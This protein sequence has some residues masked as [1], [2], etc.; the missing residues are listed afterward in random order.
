[1]NKIFYILVIMLIVLLL[2]PR[3][4]TATLVSY[5]LMNGVTGDSAPGGKVSVQQFPNF[6]PI[7][8]DGQYTYA[9]MNPRRKQTPDAGIP[10]SWVCTSSASFCTGANCTAP[11]LQV[12]SPTVIPP[13]TGFIVTYHYY[14]FALPALND[15]NEF[16]T[17]HQY[18]S[19]AN[20][21]YW[22]PYGTSYCPL[23]S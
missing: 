3:D 8:P 19:V 21:H 14:Q 16:Y 22:S 18:H 13:S 4:A 5:P 20:F 9:Y 17:S 6:Q 15:F 11:P 23:P 1:M 10:G 7:G 12:A 2:V